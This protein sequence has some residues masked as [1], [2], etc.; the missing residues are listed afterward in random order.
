MIL[1]RIFLYLVCFFSIG[2]SLL[3]FGGPFLIKRVILGYT[4]GALQPSEITVS[5]TFEIYISRLD[6]SID[7][8][9]L[10]IPVEGFSRAVEISWSLFGEEPFLDLFLGRS[11]FKNYAVASNVNISFP[12]YQD[13]DWENT[14]LV[15]DVE[16]L[17]LNSLG[18]AES[19]KLRGNVN[20]LTSKVLN[21]ELEA[22]SSSAK[23]GSSIYGSKSIVGQIGDLNFAA[24]AKEQLISGVIFMED[25]TVSEPYIS[26]PEA[27][28]EFYL[29]ADSKNFQINLNDLMLPEL[30]GFIGNIKVDGNY[31]S[32]YT[33]QNLNVDLSNGTFDSGLPDFSNISTTIVKKNEEIY[34]AYVE[35]DIKNYEISNSQTFLGSLPPSSFELK[36]KLDEKISKVTTTSQINFK[37]VGV[38]DIIGSS[39]LI[40]KSGRVDLIQCL[41]LNC[42]LSDLELSYQLDFNGDWVKGNAWCPINFC[43]LENIEYRL[44]TSDTANLFTSL[45]DAGILSPLTSFYLYGILSSGKQINKGHEINF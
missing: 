1:L 9:S 8:Q 38:S 23:V 15:A 26:W 13:L 14:P 22:Q 21:F 43:G 41:F 10:E 33:L 3:V 39:E 20:F 31:D 37:K 35:G 32:V 6:F 25:I 44:R 11:V 34:D 29:T 18:T 30:N 5:P 16:N 17:T 19:L 4:N 24:P 28:M 36:L 45:S 40:F 2:W 7:N 42:D 27:T 12:S